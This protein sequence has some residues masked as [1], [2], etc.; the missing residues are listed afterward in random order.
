MVG[1]TTSKELEL[2]LTRKVVNQENY[3]I[4]GVTAEIGATFKYLKETGW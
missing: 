1:K 2:P 3:H 4:P